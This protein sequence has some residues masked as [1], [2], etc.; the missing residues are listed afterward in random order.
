M[1]PRTVAN[2]LSLDQVDFISETLAEAPCAVRGLAGTMPDI[3]NDQME[4][5]GYGLASQEL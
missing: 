2:F 3:C 1:K 5:C 4:A